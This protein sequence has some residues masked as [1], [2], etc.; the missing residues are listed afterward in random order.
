LSGDTRK[1]VKWWVTEAGGEPVG[2]VTT[3]LLLEGIRAGKV[4]NRAL[5]CRAGESTWSSIGE[6]PELAGALGEDEPTERIALQKL[7]ASLPPLRPF[8]GEEEKT[9]AGAT[10]FDSDEPPS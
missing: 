10:W 2:P 3:E 7:R 1:P 8:T 5:A 4:S 9:V 6:F